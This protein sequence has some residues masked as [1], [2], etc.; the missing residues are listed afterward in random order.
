MTRIASA[1]L[2]LW[3]RALSLALTADE[4]TLFTVKERTR[5]APLIGGEGESGN[6]KIVVT[7]AVRLRKK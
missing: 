2:E 3:K 6:G 5:I 4:S 7:F 1:S